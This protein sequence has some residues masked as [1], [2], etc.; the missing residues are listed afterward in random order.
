VSYLRL[1]FVAAAAGFLLAWAQS[2]ALE[3]RHDS[4]VLPIDPA[5]PYIHYAAAPPQR[6]RILVVHGLDVSKE[7]MNIIS[8]ALA[9]GGFEV[10]A[11]DLP[12]HGDS[13]FPFQMDLA[14]QAI[15]NAYAFVGKDAAVLGHSLGAGL[16]MDLAATEQ[17]AT[18]ILLSPP[19]VEISQIHAN[20]VLIATGDI[21]VPRIRAFLPVAADIANTNVDS[22]LLPWSGHSGPVFNP[23]YIRR[24]V[25]WLGG[26]GSRTRTGRRL[27]WIGV[28][29]LSATWVGILL[30]PGAKLPELRTPIPALLGRYAVACTAALTILRLVNPLSW[31]NIFATDYLVGFLLISG[32]VLI[33]TLRLWEPGDNRAL[34]QNCCSIKGVIQACGAAAFTILVFGLVTGS[35]L[36]HTTLPDGRWWRFLCIVVA[37]LPLFVYDELMIR[38][39]FPAWRAAAMALITRGLFLAFLLTGVLTFNREK[40]FLVL[41][42]PLIVV[43]W[44]GLW[45]ITGVVHRGTR[46][47]VSAAIFAAIVQGWAFAA[48]FVTISG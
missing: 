24:D 33:L 17:F 18:M 44:I 13:K 29:F 28:M 43:F 10:Y 16:L 8:E 36:L 34:F 6:G 2:T 25:E 38:R 47:P 42:V 14:E 46:E 1:E 32:V 37:G 11:I 15:H 12:G 26:D 9:D 23:S 35:H 45:F 3:P 40:V 19:P 27:F 39:L 41:I 31:L 20:R 22:W 30:M 4:G 48:L 21:D 5:T 7:V